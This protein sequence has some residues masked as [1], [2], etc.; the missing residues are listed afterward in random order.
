[1]RQKASTASLFQVIA[2][3]ETIKHHAP[4]GQYHPLAEI[5]VLEIFLEAAIQAA[6]L[7]EGRSAHHQEAAGQPVAVKDLMRAAVSIQVAVYLS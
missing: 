4:T 1:M 3:C 7:L 2:V 6:H 5:N